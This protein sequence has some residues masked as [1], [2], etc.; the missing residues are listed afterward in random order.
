MIHECTNYPI[1]SNE[2]GSKF[3][4]PDL[5]CASVTVE[6]VPMCFVG[7]PT[8]QFRAAASSEAGS[9]APCY[10]RNYPLLNTH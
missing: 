8:P 3:E 9:K 2:I 1:D 5:L 7:L 10:E 6:S 4:T